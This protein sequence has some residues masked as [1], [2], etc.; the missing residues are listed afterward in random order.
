MGVLVHPN[1]TDEQA[2]GAAF[3]MEIEYKVTKEGK[4]A[5]K[6]TRPWLN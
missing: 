2:N 3:A 6:Q 1:F 5:I 4:V